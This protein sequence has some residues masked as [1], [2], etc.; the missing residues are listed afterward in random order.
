VIAFA[1]HHAFTKK[2]IRTIRVK[3]SKMTNDKP[4]II[5]TEKDAA[6]IRTNP[7]F[8]KEW[9]SRMYFL[10]IKINFFNN[11]DQHNFDK[12]I[13]EHISSMIENNTKNDATN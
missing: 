6:R 10:P 11:R 5:C 2:D 7:Y 3:L 1:D 13:F 12:Q 9:K 8:P 4:L